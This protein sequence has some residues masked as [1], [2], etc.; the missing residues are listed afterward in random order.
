MEAP[1]VDT[2]ALKVNQ[3]CIIAFVVLAFL[4]GAP[5]PGLGLILF[6]AL[7]LGVGTVWPKLA[8]FKAFYQYVL[9][10]AGVLKP[11]VIPDNPNAHLFA[12]GLGSAFLFASTLAFLL[13]APVVGWAL[14]WVVAFLAA[15]N[16]V[17]N[18]CAGCFVYYQLGRYG[19]LRN[20]HPVPKEAR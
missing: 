9:R 15:V 20:A 8:L 1:R 13:N 2:T 16:L 18:F 3:S 19:I 11:R 14:A 10:P 12:Q 17:F 7:V 4:F 5:G 6:T